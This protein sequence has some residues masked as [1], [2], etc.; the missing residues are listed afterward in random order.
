M[1]IHNVETNKRILIPLIDVPPMEAPSPPN[2]SL[3]TPV[4]PRSFQPLSIHMPGSYSLLDQPS[5]NVSRSKGIRSIVINPS[6]TLLA[7][8]AE[9]PEYVG[10]YKLPG[11]EPL[12][13][14]QGHTDIIFSLA[15][16]DDETLVSGSRDHNLALWKI[17]K[18]LL[19]H[20]RPDLPLTTVKPER[21]RKEHYGKV[22]D[23]KYNPQTSVRPEYIRMNSF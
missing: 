17:P 20:R 6:R 12:C 18:E 14:L 15:W 8:S 4:S 10:I 9:Q 21:M 11:F 5:L 19:L 2:L 23:L 16:L 1:F 7:A 13:L 22:R 3:T